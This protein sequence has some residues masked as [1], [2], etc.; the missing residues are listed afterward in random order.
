MIKVY[1]FITGLVLYQFT[2]VPGGTS[3]AILGSGHFAI[4][5]IPSADHTITIKYPG[6]AE[7]SVTPPLEVQLTVAC[8][9]GPCPPKG[10]RGIETPELIPSLKD[11][12]TATPVIQPACLK[13]GSGS[14]DCHPHDALTAPGRNGLLAF[15]GDWSVEALTDCGGSTYPNEPAPT[16]EMN[17]VRAG[18]SWDLRYRDLGL[19]PKTVNTVLFTTMVQRREDLVISNASNGQMWTSALVPID[20]CK[21]L[22]GFEA[23]RATQCAVILIRNGSSDPYVGGGDLHYAALYEL[24]TNPPPIND[25]FLPIVS[26]GNVCGGGGGTGGMSHCTGLK[27]TFP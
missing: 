17:F 8:P 26:T 24:L 10:C 16:V 20:D 19:L 22:R 3:Y 5:S 21:K 1:V 12:M 18:R 15:T 6:Q 11:L 23:S 2:S 9:S 25:F 27:V 13:F 7:T 4:G 14:A